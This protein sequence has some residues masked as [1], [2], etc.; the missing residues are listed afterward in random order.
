MKILIT[1]IHH[2][3][4]GG[5]VTYVLSLLDGLKHDCDITLAVPPT[6]RLYKTAQQRD[7]IRVVPGLYTSRLVTLI[8]EV[9]RLRRFLQQEQFDVVHA[10]GAADHRHLML[11]CLGMRNRPAIVWTRH[12]TNPA[13]SIGNRLRAYLGTDA[14]IA[15]CDYVAQ[16]LTNSAYRRRPIHVVRNG[17]DI[18]SLKP[19]TLAER[20]QYRKQ[21]FGNID[22]D[23]IVLGSVGGTDHNK[24]W[25][26]LAEAVSRLDPALKQRVRMVVAGDPPQD[27]LLE[28]LQQF[29]L[30]P[31]QVVF[32]GLVKDIRHILSACDI[33]FVLSFREAASYASCETMAMGLPTLVSNAGGL[34]E[35][36]HHGVHG[37]VVSVGEVEPLVQI[38]QSVLQQ[39]DALISLGQSARQRVEQAFCMQKF[40]HD[41]K[42]VY[43]DALK[44][45]RGAQ[46]P[47]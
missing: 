27:D 40:L 18:T 19:A 15:V 39:P 5:H 8:S 13:T 34:P 28:K 26:L 9:V 25:L 30:S 14:T 33:G 38:L 2:A 6:G 45:A 20:S 46:A 44:T 10:N 22:N 7:G 32:P 36:V 35:N 24:G 43:R 12:N 23:T 11:A 16:I 31:D 17:I 1:D 47:I 42:Q 37:W 29:S 4:G 41:T 21:L 3:N